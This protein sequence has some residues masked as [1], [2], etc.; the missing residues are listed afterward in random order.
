MS[1]V[2]EPTIETPRLPRLAETAPDFTAKSTHGEIRLSDYTSKGKY[3]LLFS[4]PSDFTPVCTTEFV[5]FAR[6][7]PEFEALNVQLIGVSIDSI[8]SHIAWVRDIEQHAGV[9]VK[10]PVIADL[11]QKVAQAYGMVHQASSD[12][13]AVRAVFAIDPQQKVRAVIYYP[14]QLGRSI[15]ELLRVF[16]GLQTVDANGVSCP[17]D[18]K[19]GDAVIVPAP[20]TQADAEKRTNGGGAG[21]DVKTWYLSKKD[22]KPTPP[23]KN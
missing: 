3:V 15:D 14:M 9:E 6:R 13:A 10:F 12:T 5:E 7:W 23:S 1:T 22:L 11:D 20:A 21:L 17:A 16:Q 18:W 2:A 4:H 19:P 8:Y